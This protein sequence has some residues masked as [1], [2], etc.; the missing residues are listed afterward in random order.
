M[1]RP[2]EFDRTA[3][4]RRAL[5]LFWRKGYQA[6]S[7]NDLVDELR[8]SR[9]S[10][11]AAYGDKRALFVACLDLFADGV[12]SVVEVAGAAP[13]PVAALRAFFKA[14][15]TAGE[16]QWGCLL[17]NTSLELAA[18]DAALAARASG[19][20]TRVEAAI[21][22]LLAEAGRADPAR[23][24]NY[25]MLVLEGLR[26]ASRRA[27]PADVHAQRIDTAFRLLEAA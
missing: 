1:A 10:F 27:L 24:A 6:T 7:L 17:V 14:G 2:V 26:V 9:S 3:A 20:L 13:D 5:R 4:L 15:A 8:I 18:E 21:A 23:L 16:A 19:H 11:Y 22:G 25:L 12:V